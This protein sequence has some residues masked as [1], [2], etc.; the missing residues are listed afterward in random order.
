MK[1]GVDHVLTGII[2]F[3]LFLN[4]GTLYAQEKTGN[5]QVTAKEAFDSGEFDLAI[6]ISEEKIRLYS[7]HQG[8]Q[9]LPYYLTSG[10][11]FLKLGFYNEAL[12]QFEK[13]AEISEK[14]NDEKWVATFINATGLYYYALKDYDRALSYYTEAA[15]LRKTI[16]DIDGLVNSYNNIGVINKHNNKLEE[17]LSY[18]ILSMEMAEILHGKAGLNYIIGLNNIGNVYRSL[19]EYQKALESLETGL[20]AS[21]EGGSKYNEALCL[22]NIGS[23]Y[24]DMGE[25]QKSK[26]YLNQSLVISTEIKTPNLIIASSQDLFK[27]NKENG[28]FEM[29]LT[30][31]QQ[32][33][34]E[35]E[36]Q[37][38]KKSER[39][40]V[41]MQT[42]FES[43]KKDKEI[44]LLE[45]ERGLEDYKRNVL[46]VGLVALLL[47]SAVIFNR[48][49]KLLKKEKQIVA[50]EKRDVGRLESELVDKNRELTNYALHLA[51]RNDF[52]RE[53]RKELGKANRSV[54]DPKTNERLKD[55][56]V[57]IHK[58]VSHNKEEEE[59]VRKLEE[60]NK[61][62]FTNLSNALPGLTDKEKKLCAL[63]RL[64]LSSKEIAS[65][66]D[67]SSKSVDMN[68]YRLRKKL[69]LEPDQDLFAFLMQY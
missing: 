63:L 47:L 4:S 60:V 17:A 9:K 62:F 24:I 22:H 68:R 20:K 28:D 7:T 32:Y 40:F 27:I 36:K 19:R 57:K 21:Q 25:T 8:K 14:I 64:Q 65:V 16:K 67:I 23:V 6:K 49:R 31:L 33:F 37:L 42:R 56:T 13:G 69:G 29:A 50:I 38:K 3:L 34:E 12:E 26:I 61:S 10:K 43:T 55:I 51:Q 1:S 54:D 41:F 15:E 48:Q 30:N 11:S 46:Y 2:V 53:M 45:K 66:I 5:H 52:L 35:L 58:Y 18:Y 44:A 39:Q 59:F